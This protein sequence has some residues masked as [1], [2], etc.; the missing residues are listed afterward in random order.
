MSTDKNIFR[1]KELQTLIIETTK[2]SGEVNFK[3]QFHDNLSPIGWHL[4]H[5]VYIESIWIRKQLLKDNSLTDRLEPIACSFKSKKN[6][7]T[8]YLNT[9][10]EL[11]IT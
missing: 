7:R 8:N 3:K 4:L 2:N 10:S 5:C 1:W 6:K 9:L 11:I